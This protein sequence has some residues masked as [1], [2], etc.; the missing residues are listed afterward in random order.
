MWLFSYINFNMGEFFNPGCLERRRETKLCV[1]SKNTESSPPKDS[2]SIFC[3]SF[4]DSTPIMSY[5]LTYL[6]TP[7]SRILLEKLTGSA[8]SQE[9]PCI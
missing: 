2:T 9:F 5:L 4:D 7:R 3:H 6:L 1:S 8:A